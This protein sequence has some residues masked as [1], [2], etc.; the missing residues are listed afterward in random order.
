M[1]RSHTQ[2]GTILAE[3]MSEPAYKR[4]RVTFGVAALALTCSAL[5]AGQSV[6]VKLSV[7]PMLPYQVMTLRFLMAAVVTGGFA[8]VTR[9]TLRINRWQAWMVLVNAILLFTQIGLFTVGTSLTTSVRSAV[10]VNSFPFFAALACHY[11]LPG[12]SFTW[13]TIVGLALAFAGV[14]SVFAG[15][16]NWTSAR[17]MNGDLMILGAA[18]VMGAKVACIKS[19]LGKIGPL[20]VVFWEVVIA[21]SMFFSVSVLFEGLQNWVATP[22]SILAVTYQG[23]AVSGI[24]F[25]LWSIVLSRHS[26][27]E[28]TV[29]RMAT[30]ILGVLLGWV[31]LDEPVTPHLLLG[32]ALLVAGI[33]YATK[34]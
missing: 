12:F 18:A 22:Q 27:N 31:I 1:S 15:E 10:I 24:A 30:P 7:P 17:G 25:L 5:W 13:K 23:V 8:L 6:A 20:Q 34:R 26:P 29:F 2:I 21:L 16:L 33:Y 32:G 14:I 9:Q 11:F 28:V 19:L 3:K 4:H